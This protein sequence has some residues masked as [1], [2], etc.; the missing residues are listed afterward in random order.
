MEIS[1][2]AQ[3]GF[4]L[5]EFF[6]VAAFIS[7]IVSIHLRKTANVVTPP[8]VNIGNLVAVNSIILAIAAVAAGYYTITY[9]VTFP[10]AL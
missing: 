8:E 6:I 1:L 7:A 4:V 3:F 2:A 10:P 9:F 5:M